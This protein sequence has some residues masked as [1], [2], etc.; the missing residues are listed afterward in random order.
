MPRSGCGRC[1]IAKIPSMRLRAPGRVNLIGEHTDYAGGFCLPVAIDRY[2]VVAGGPADGLRL[3]SV[4]ADPTR[5]VEAI[6]TELTA[7]GRPSVGFSG[8]VTGDL[9]VG[10]GLGS[11]GAFGVAVGLALCLVARF[12][13]DPIVLADA[14]RRAEA[15]ASGVRGGILDQAA[16]AL[17]RAG[18]AV[19][20]DCGKLEYAHVPLPDEIALFVVESGVRR[21]VRD[22]AY[23]QRRRELEAGHSRRVRHVETENERVLAA[24]EAL[25]R[26]DRR[27][28]SQLFAASQRSLRDDFEV[29]TPELDA[30]VDLCLALG[31]F[32]ARLTGAGFGG[33]VVA[34][35]DADRAAGIV[36]ALGRTHRVHVCRAAD[37]AG[38]LR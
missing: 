16:S 8:T 10:A 23:A 6:S 35:T 11:S 18:H 17:G 31:A 36:D 25:H 7:L 29:S 30:L 5:H 15:Q 26:D 37:G 20:L 3:S 4:V 34:L 19:F 14:C 33:S 13:L 9:P 1:R 32:A 22:T 12:A 21:R 27:A 38:E 2:V 28:L 24:V